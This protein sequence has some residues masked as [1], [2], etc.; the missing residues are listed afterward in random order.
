MY[1]SRGLFTQLLRDIP[2][3]SSHLAK[4]AMVVADKDFENAIEKI[5]GENEADLKTAEKEAVAF[6]LRADASGFLRKLL[7]NLIVRM[8]TLILLLGNPKIQSASEYLSPSMFL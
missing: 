5:Q 6:L 7:I 1:T 4:D 3:L 2:E 8:D